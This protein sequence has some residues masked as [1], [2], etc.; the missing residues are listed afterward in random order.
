MSFCLK[1]QNLVVT[2]RTYF[3]VNDKGKVPNRIYGMLL[4]GWKEKNHKFVK[5]NG[6]D[7]RNERNLLFS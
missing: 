3:N 2:L 6:W 4:F 7:Q 5:L 1:S